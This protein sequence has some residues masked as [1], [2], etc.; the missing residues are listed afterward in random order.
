MLCPKVRRSRRS[1]RSPSPMTAF[2]CF[3]SSHS[4]PIPRPAARNP[5]VGYSAEG[6]LGTPHGEG[7]RAARLI[8]PAALGRHGG[9]EQESDPTAVVVAE[10]IRVPKSAAAISLHGAELAPRQ[11]GGPELQLHGRPCRRQLSTL[12]GNRPAEHDRPASHPRPPGG[13]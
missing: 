9:A 7:A 2:S 4:L 6:N 10:A 8:R 1:P 13:Y 5:T 12:E 11:T 3:P